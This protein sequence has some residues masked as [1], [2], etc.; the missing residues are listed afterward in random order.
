MKKLLALT[1][2]IAM[3]LCI[4]LAAGCGDT[5]TET[6]TG[7]ST[8]ETTTTNSSVEETTTSS[9]NEETEATGGVEETEAT[10]ETTEAGPVT[11]VNPM[12]TWDGYTKLPGFEDIDFRG[13]TFV[14]AGKTTD[15]VS[16]P[17]DIEIYTEET[18]AVSTAVRERNAT[19][20]KLYNCKIEC[21]SSEDPVALVSAEVSSGKHTI[22]MYARYTHGGG[23]ATGGS[24][25]NLY[26][27]G[28]DFSN[29][30]WDQ[31]YVSTYTIKNSAGTSVLYATVGDFAITAFTA[32]HAMMFNKSVYET[33]IAQGL[34]YDIYQL[35]RDGKWTM[36]IFVEMVKKAGTDVSGNSE[37][38]Y[39]EG[40]ILGWVRTAHAT[41]G[42]HA[43]SGLP[44]ITNDNGTLK[45]TAL[46][47]TNQ[48]TTVVDKSIEVWALP[49]A[50][51]LGY[52][53]VREALTS[54]NTL[55]ASEVLDVLRRMRDADVSAGLVPYPKYSETQENYAHY[56][57]GHVSPYSVPV[58]VTE[59]ETM[60]KFIELYAAH[61][62]KIVRTAWIDTY[63]YEYCG[64]ADSTEMLDIILNTRT[65]DPGYLYWSTYEA[66]VSQMISSGKNNF[67]KWVDKRANSLVGSGGELETLIAGIDDN[68]A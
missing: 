29:S 10:E 15:D 19:I 13:T 16:F 54:G 42:L 3:T 6:T 60:G 52:T 27:L 40:D 32:T 65:Y 64:D 22:D 21:I 58:S 48:W 59:I 39:S 49:E 2:A 31:N 1:L 20:E 17:T 28:I 37:Y 66:E 34:G 25:Y 4:C 24:N 46:E 56:V 51:T 12:E 30:W 63:C 62:Q 26:T 9:D 5:S 47:Y 11:P 18:D 53:N 55:F 44:L 57:D 35:V 8:T 14:L 38:A 68:K 33:E 36:D 7:K 23:E 45:F 43:A 61:S 50:E 41:H 67:T